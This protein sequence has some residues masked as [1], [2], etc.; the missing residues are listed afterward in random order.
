[1]RSGVFAQTIVLGAALLLVSCGKPSQDLPPAS[2]A[3]PQGITASAQ[4]SSTKKNV[5]TRELFSA[6]SNNDLGAH[7]L[8]KDFAGTVIGVT[9]VYGGGYGGSQFFLQIT[10]QTTK[11][12]KVQ[13]PSYF[14]ANLVGW[15]NV[16]ADEG[17]TPEFIYFCK[18]EKAQEFLVEP[19]GVGEWGLS[20]F[21]YLGNVGRP[22]PTLGENPTKF[23]IHAIPK[24][25][26]YSK[27]AEALEKKTPAPSSRATQLFFT[28][29]SQATPEQTVRQAVAGLSSIEH[30]T[31][32]ELIAECDPNHPSLKYLT[33]AQERFRETLA[34][35]SDELQTFQQNQNSIVG[36]QVLYAASD[37]SFHK[38][39]REDP[40]IAEVV[41][42]YLQ[43]DSTGSH[44]EMVVALLAHLKAKSPAIRDALWEA[45]KREATP[46]M[47]AKIAYA[48]LAAG[49][50]RAAAYL[51]HIALQ[52]RP[53]N[54]PDYIYDE[55]IKVLRE[56]WEIVKN[57]DEKDPLKA[58]K[59]IGGLSAK[60]FQSLSS[61]D[62]TFLTS[63]F[64]Q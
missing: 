64:P 7:F 46:R 4:A 59:E 28:L 55:S 16:Y 42:K 30:P 48:G 8:R 3:K 54:D 23:S 5:E 37:P 39:Y 43:R 35:L 32:Q 31:I 18:T 34:K 29:F 15:K 10:N 13:C 44:P 47:K 25:S 14:L 50:P 21:W 6:I 56:E 24:D 1:M 53:A 12:L 26:W 45:L 20:N 62:R 9:F 27:A 11:P 2:D 52:P 60:E 49:D 58:W 33:E 19:R 36:L 38:A 17:P 57:R 61:E 41:V 40:R 51:M 63:L 22:Q